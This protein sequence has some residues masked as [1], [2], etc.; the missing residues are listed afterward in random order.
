MRCTVPNNFLMNPRIKQAVIF[1]LV[2]LQTA[3]LWAHPIPDVPVRTFFPG[4]G[5]ARVTVE[6]DPRCFDADPATAPSLQKWVYDAMNPAD[7]KELEQKAAELVQRYV[8]FTLE[9]VGRVQPEFKFSFTGHSG[10]ALKGTEDVVV[11]TGE[12]KTTLAAGLSGWRIRSTEKA[13]LAVVFQNIIGGKVHERIAVLF[14]GE[15]SFSLDLAGLAVTP[16]A[17]RGDRVPAEGSAGDRWSTFGTYLRQ[18]FVHVV[19]EGLDHIL[20]VL[21]LFLLSRTWKPLLAQ[22]TTFTLA[23]S[24]TLALA[25]LGTVKVSPTIVEPIIAASIAFVA[26]ENIFRPRYSHWRLLVVFV[27]GLIHGLGFASALGDLELPRNSLAVG[28]VGFNVGVEGGQLAVIAGA[29]LLTGWLRNAAQ[30]RRWIV[31]PGSALI[32]LCG[33][34]W[35][36]ERIA[37]N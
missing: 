5:T 19:P 16:A 9:P 34:V 1:S 33:V 14:P 22:V 4:D 29:F 23:H 30:Y 6:V 31:I 8:E 27:F 15:K 17:E 32:A 20:F 12:W 7:R 2:L 26:L 11:L 18:G 10:E 37:G 36:I 35:T 21:G 25:T 24:V 28:L 3:I 13:K